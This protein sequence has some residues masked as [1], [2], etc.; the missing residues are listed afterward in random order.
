VQVEVKCV[1]FSNLCSKTTARL[2]RSLAQKHHL[3][4]IANNRLLYNLLGIACTRYHAH[5]CIY[6]SFAED[7]YFS[8]V[9]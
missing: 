6:L 9:A 1:A 5:S 8:S 4:T 2:G 7:K 3:F